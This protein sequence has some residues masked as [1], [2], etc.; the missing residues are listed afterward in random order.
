MPR[1]TRAPDPSSLDVAFKNLDKVF[2]PKTRFTK[3]DVIRYYLEVAPWLLPHFAD[4]PVTL[5]RYPEGVRGEFFYEKDAPGYTPDWV[6]RFP[7]PRREGGDPIEYILLNDARVLAWCVNLGTI[8]LHPFLHRAPALDCPTAVAFDLDPGEGVDLR[9]CAKVALQLRELFERLQLQSFP[10][11]SGSKGL[12]LYVPLNTPTTY[13]LTQAFARTVA[14]L[15]HRQHPERIVA[16]MAKELRRG[17]VFIDWSQNSDFKTTIG[18]YSLRAKRDEP[19]VSMPITWEEV[20]AARTKA[21]MADLFFAPDVALRRLQDVGDLFAPVLRIRQRLPEQFTGAFTRRQRPA[22]GARVMGSSPP[23]S[24]RRRLESYAAKRDFAV[25]PEPAAVPRRSAQGSRRRFVIQKHAASHLHYDLRLEMN[26]TLKS[27]AVPKGLPTSL[28]VR[29]SAFATEDHPL[30][31]VSFEG[32]IPPG[33]YGGGTVMV[34]DIGTYEVMEGNYWKGHLRVYIRGKKLKGEWTLQRAEERNGKTRWVVSKTGEPMKPITATREDQSAL[35]RRTMEDIAKA[36]DAVWESNRATSPGENPGPGRRASGRSTAQGA[37]T[38]GRAG[39][40]TGE[41]PQFVEPMLARPVTT[42]PAEEGWIYEVKW[43]GYRALAVKDGADVQ[44]L[45][46][47]NKRMTSDFPAVVAAVRGLLAERVVLDGEI[48]ALDSTG[49]PQFQLLQNRASAKDAPIVYY[50][51]DLVHLEGE[52]LTREPLSERKARLAE[53]VAGTEVRFSANLPGRPAEILTQAARLGLE[54]IVAKRS[55]AQ[56]EPGERSGHWQKLKLS[57]EQEFVIGGYKPGR[58]LESLLVGYY[59]RG[60]LLFAGKVRQGLNPRLRRELAH[61]LAPWATADCPF[62]NLPNSKKSHFGEGVTPAQMKELRW[63]Q[64][65]VVVQVSFA[66][67]TTSGNLRHATFLGLREDK[68]PREV[69]REAAPAPRR[70]RKRAPRRSIASS[71]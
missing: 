44:L 51:Y 50:V 34:W 69:A 31:Y 35:T 52:D 21:G 11:V 59:E 67:W 54:G 53:L 3:G 7:V 37:R 5:K 57:P 25:T 48:V 64:P 55:D 45:S 47:K 28:E 32:V 30:D 15:L 26:D 22:R 41:S 63:T 71:G 66:E 38:N 13:D 39:D 10:K 42:L 58:P 8:E 70:A 49:R 43:D 46:R 18:V 33:Q 68:E 20:E 1:R 2:Y 65:R 29:H 9:D 16:E 61:V 23:G 19:F 12:Q 27:W 17:K 14:E 24:S 6:P 60:K 4:R 36:R 40:R 56:Y 62:A